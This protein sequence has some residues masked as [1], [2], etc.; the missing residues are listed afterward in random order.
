MSL[1]ADRLSNIKPSPTLAVVKRVA[2]MK[3]EGKSVIGLGAGEPDFDTPAWIKQAASDA[4]A[5]GQTKYTAVEGVIE[6]RK[7]IAENTN[8]I[9]T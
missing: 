8:E 1:I 3:A 4:M 6:L 2:E 5:K 7:A 9:I